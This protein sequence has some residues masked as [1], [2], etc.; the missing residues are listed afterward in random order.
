[1]RTEAGGQIAV[2]EVM[3]TD[4]GDDGRGMRGDLDSIPESRRSPRGGH[5]SPLQYSCLKN[6][7]DRGTC[8]VQS[9]GS[10]RVRH[11]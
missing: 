10:Q 3:M 9:T 6:P 7:M 4:L 8:W 11:N 1:M 2:G 5:G